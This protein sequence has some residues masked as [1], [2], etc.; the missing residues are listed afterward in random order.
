MR[1]PVFNALN[2][3]KPSKLSKWLSKQYAWLHYTIRFSIE[4]NANIL[5]PSTKT[6]HT[7]FIKPVSISF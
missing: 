3:L 4:D 1:E 6:V 2:I 5:L 7:K